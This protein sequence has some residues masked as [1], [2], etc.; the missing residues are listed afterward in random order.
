LTWRLAGVGDLQRLAAEQPDEFGVHDLDHL[1]GRVERLR[2]LRADGLVADA[3][4][5]AAHHPDV[6]VGLDQ[7]Y[8]KYF[9]LCATAQDEAN[10]EASLRQPKSVVAHGLLVFLKGTC[11]SVPDFLRQR[12]DKRLKDPLERH[13]LSHKL[14]DEGWV[15]LRFIQR[16]NQDQ[17]NTACTLTR[18]ILPK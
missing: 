11:L 12:F 8:F 9:E 17:S 1:L 18:Q 7:R 16:P 6:H 14:L 2:R 3:R 5:H 10:R 4:Q 13:V 15:T